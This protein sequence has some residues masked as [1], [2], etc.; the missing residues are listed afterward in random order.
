MANIFAPPSWQAIDASGNPISGARLYFYQSGTTTLLTVYQDNGATTPHA[1]PVIADAAGRFPAIYTAVPTYKVVL[2]DAG[3]VT[4]QTIDPVGSTVEGLDYDAHVDDVAA[5]AAYNGEAAGY[6]VLVDD[7]GGGRAG[8][9][10][11]VTPGGSAVW[12]GPAYVTGATGS[13]GPKGDTG[14]TGAQGPAGTVET[15]GTKAALVSGDK[16]VILNSE[17]SDA[18]VTATIE[19]LQAAVGGGVSLPQG[20]L[21]LTSGVAAPESDVS[22]AT[23]VYYLPNGGKYVPVYNGAAFVAADIGTG[24]SLPLDSDSGHTGYQ[25]SSKNFDLFIFNDAG[26]IRL[27]SGPAW[28]VGSGS[29]TA[30]GTG[31]GSTEL[32]EYEGLP[33][34]K[35]SITLRFGASSGNTVS[36][37]ARQATYVGSFRATANGQATDS[38]LKRLLFNAFNR[39]QRPMRVGDPATSWTYST[40][41]WRQSNGNA[42]NKVEF[43]LGL[44]GI[45]VQAV[46]ITFANNSTST[47]RGLFNGIGLD[48]TSAPATDSYTGGTGAGTVFK[49][50]TAIYSGFPGLGY[51]YLAM[52]E[53]GAG[54]DTQTWFGAI[55]GSRTGMTAHFQG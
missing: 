17:D 35:N 31:A 34:N 1:N 2:K 3:D 26:T 43:L 48:S 14:D 51:H 54:A 28:N 25:E 10:T 18:I 42:A 5:R 45:G 40:D 30:R 53:I 50:L 4:I 13:Q 32:E 24:L 12:Q 6:R 41:A 33:V 46:N 36:V 23:T 44:A 19:N 8:I 37:A 29:N 11:L 38:A 39:V 55:G 49:S 16:V 7:T 22:G 47:E 52:L 27:G 21:S 9:Y 20:R 15:T